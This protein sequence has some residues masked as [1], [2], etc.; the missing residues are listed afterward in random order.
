MLVMPAIHEFPGY[1]WGWH[2][3]RE[4]LLAVNNLR[5]KQGH[6]SFRRGE[7]IEAFSEL[8]Y[9]GK[10]CSL[11]REGTRM[12]K[13]ANPFDPD[14]RD[15]FVPAGWGIDV[16]N[17][18]KAGAVRIRPSGKKDEWLGVKADGSEIVI[19]AA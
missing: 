2:C 16:I 7:M 15:A 13:C 6:S 17:A 10:W 11:M 14:N 5:A 3:M 4:L 18:V 8:L 19:K 9:D 1:K 12:R